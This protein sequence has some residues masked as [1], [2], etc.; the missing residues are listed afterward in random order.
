MIVQ[1]MK[2]SEN[3]TWYDVNVECLITTD[4][5]IENFIA[6]GTCGTFRTISSQANGLRVETFTIKSEIVHILADRESEV[7]NE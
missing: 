1:R 4:K 7:T 6:A 3:D 5:I 2:L